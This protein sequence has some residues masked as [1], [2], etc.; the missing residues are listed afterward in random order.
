MTD[1]PPPAAPAAGAPAAAPANPG[2]TLGVV[3]LI[4][5]ILPF[6]LI[7]IILGFVALNQSKKA[8][9]KNGVAV[10]AIVI[11]FILMA[12]GIIVSIVLAVSGAAIFGGL[13]DVCSQLG[14]GV[15]DVDG[16]TYTCG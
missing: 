13:L 7:G 10:A 4:L 15:W 3:A 11:G 14:P 1:A 8:G 16:V 2:K 6:Q 5:S 9:Q 12:I